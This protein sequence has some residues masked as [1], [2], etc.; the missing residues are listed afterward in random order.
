MF[1][2]NGFDSNKPE[3]KLA[4]LGIALHN[5]KYGL[6]EFITHLEQYRE[7]GVPLEYLNYSVMNINNALSELYK[8]DNETRSNQNGRKDR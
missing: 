1:Y 2:Q 7:L 3:L 5:Y 8:I 6:Q 4:Q